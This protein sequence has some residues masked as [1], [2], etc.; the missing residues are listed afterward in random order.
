MIWSNW[1]YLAIGIGLG[2]GSRWLFVR[3]NSLSNQRI[4]IEIAGGVGGAG[5]AKENSSVCAFASL[6]DQNPTG[7][8]TQEVSE[9]TEKLKQTEIAYQLAHQMSKFKAG[10]LARTSHELRSPLNSLI[11]LH[12]LILSDLCDDPAEERTFIAQANSSALKLIDLIDQILEVS[13]LEHGNSKLEIQ[14]LQLAAVLA[15]VYNS[16][17]LVAANRNIRLQLSPPESEIYV[18]ADPWWLRQALLNL[19]DTCLTQMEEGSICV[20][21]CSTSAYSRSQAEPG[22]ESSPPMAADAKS[23]SSQ[24]YAQ[25]W[26]DVN[27]PITIW[28]EPV[29]SLQTLQSKQSVLKNTAPSFGMSLLLTQT[30]L[31]LMQGS[32]E[33]VFIPDAADTNEQTRIQLTI[34][35]MIP[36]PETASV[37]LEGD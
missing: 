10:F 37:S 25:I 28:S 4:P 29:D 5:G 13:R 30:L 11:G 26:L 16:T 14:P 36:E 34:P 7:S 15:E 31:E 6:R 19:L 33:I 3:S 20:S 24:N 2:V 23:N 1:I 17:H 35:L 9:L 8:T 32:L 22:N 12:Q 21:T 18:L 27:L